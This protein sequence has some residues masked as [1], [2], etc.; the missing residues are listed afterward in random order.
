VKVWLRA[1][2]RRPEWVN[3]NVRVLL[4]ARM[5]MSAARALAAVVVPI[6]LAVIG[7]SAEELGVLFL[8]GGLAA[9]ALSSLSGLL[10][11]RIG[12]RPFLVIMPLLA[13]GAAAA[14]AGTRMTAV[15]FLGAA[16]GSFG[17]GAG[18]GAGAI[19]PYQAVESA[20]LTQSVPGPRRNAAFGLVYA[21]SS[22]G[23]LAG[24]LLA[25]LAGGTHVTAAEALGAYR[26]AFLAAAALAAIAGLLGLAVREPEPAPGGTRPPSGGRRRGKIRFPRRSRGLL[27]RLWATNTVNGLA[28]GM[29]GPFVTYW[30][31]RRFGVG[32][33]QVGMLFAVINAATI[34]CSLVAAR[35][36]RRLGLVRAVVLMRATQAVLLVPM[37]LAPTFWFA[38]AVYLVRMGVQRIQ[39]PLRQSF[40]LSAADP[41]ELASVAALAQLPSQVTMSGAPMFTGYLFEETALS[42]PFMLAGLLQAANAV[43]FW[44]FF[45]AAAP[46]SERPRPRAPGAEPE[47]ARPGDH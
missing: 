26:P 44:L 34:G 6:Y 47:L 36:A 3:R 5:A 11:D 30:F 43:L 31:Y 35:V 40:V 13:A 15:L 9:A 19:G 20:V 12:R 45:R 28:V 8:A 2:G 10:S 1:A 7:F 29:F 42:L 23:A 21:G 18:A 24:G 17:R 41:G 46:D 33:A 25:A 14:Y 37:A 27:T 38:G 32:A 16:L 4:A 39:M 22:V